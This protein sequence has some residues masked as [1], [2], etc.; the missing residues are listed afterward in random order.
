MK[1]AAKKAKFFK[2]KDLDRNT[3]LLLDA[4]YQGGPKGN[5]SDDP[6][7]KLI[8]G[9]PNQGGF[10]IIGGRDLSR[11][12]G[13]ILTSS[14]AEPDWP[15]RLDS[16]AGQFIYYGDN[17]TPGHG[18]LDTP[19]GGNRLLEQIFAAAD[20]GDGRKKIPP[21]LIFTK[22]GIGRDI[23]FR[24]LAVPDLSED[25]GLIAIWRQTAGRRFQNYKATFSIIDCNEVPR[26]WLESF[27]EQSK[28]SR[29]QSAPLQWSKWVGKGATK[30]LRA[31]KTVRIRS[32]AE[33]L[34]EGSDRASWAIIDALRTS[35]KTSY[36]F[37]FIAAE[38]FRLI[39]PRLFE[40]EITR[41]RVDWGRDAFGR[42]RLGGN[43]LDS[44]G[45]FVEFSLEAKNYKA[46]SGIGVG[47]TSRLISRLRHRQF[48]VLVTTSYVSKQAYKELRHDEHPIIIISAKDIVAI[49]RK[50]SLSKAE[51]VKE[52]V[53][54]ILAKETT[55]VEPF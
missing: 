41:E 20:S 37:E 22:N 16:E 48:G 23:C 32:K 4:I 40:I 15:D 14:G 17:R 49:L 31:P 13:V 52:W 28:E 50:N 53:V 33:Q 27:R 30:I 39:E 29:T 38:I 34:P 9:C 47:E 11:C 3:P 8:P 2:F 18:L 21:I 43:D 7:T 5:I 26:R 12:S 42:L 46:T 36:E 51:E 19:K 10:R 6:L 45:I 35:I 55:R 44:D 54:R 24:G 1:F 25:G